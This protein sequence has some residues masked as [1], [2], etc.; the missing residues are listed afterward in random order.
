MEFSILILL[1]LIFTLFVGCQH[2]TVQDGNG[3]RTDLSS[4]ETYTGSDE[5]MPVKVCQEDKYT[6]KNVV[7]LTVTSL[8]IASNS[9]E[10]R[11][12][13]IVKGSDNRFYAVLPSRGFLVCI[14]L[15]TGKSSQHIFDG[16]T[17]AFPYKS[18]ASQGG[19]FYTG[20]NA[21]FYEFDPV[22]KEFT[23]I[24]N[25]SSMGANL[26]GWGFCE[27][28]EGFIYF[29]NY[30]KLYLYAFDPQTKKVTNLGLLDDV[31]MYSTTQAADSCGWVY[32]A[33]GTA[34]VNIIGYN[35]DTGEIKYIFPR[36]PGTG[37]ALV[38]KTRLG[39]VVAK[40][41]VTGKT[42]S[43]MEYLDSWWV[44][45]NG[46]I[47]DKALIT[48]NYYNNDYPWGL[49]IPYDDAP[50]FLNADYPAHTFTYWHPE[51]DEKTTV[52]FDYLCEGAACSPITLGPDGMIYGT[53]NHPMNVF[54]VDPLTDTVTDHG[55]KCIGSSVGNICAY[56]YQGDI[57]VG[58][59]Y[60]GGYIYRI[61]TKQGIISDK[62][63]INPHQE[64]IVSAISRPRSALALSDGK[65]CLFSGYGGYGVVGAGMAIYNVETRKTS[66]I[67]NENMLPYHG[68][69]AMAELPNGNV[70]CGS[71]V[72]PQ[73]GALPVCNTA[74]LFEFNPVTYEITNINYPMNNVKEIAQLVWAG[75]AVHGITT[76]GIYFVY[77][78]RTLKIIYQSNLSIYGNVVRQSM[79]ACSDGTIYLLM[80][81]SILKI[82]PDE[83]TV[84]CIGSLPKPAT[85][86]VAVTKNAVYYC[87][88]SEV[89]K[90]ALHWD[91]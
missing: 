7:S 52:V 54:T 4:V 60:S 73:G 66:V 62:S 30:P 70:I 8:G 47:V 39:E 49:H 67:E 56:A 64:K 2:N 18:F 28:D 44:L 45:K 78:Y 12:G 83:Y 23:T 69:L 11:S 59:A 65:T 35:T 91:D 50:N 3:E 16:N 36:L 20:A 81:K 88:G 13:A 89:C 37:S 32:S 71:T 5:T 6:Y 76:N 41:S 85:T 25:L 14:D 31:Q 43:D 80:S 15:H 40:M 17:S 51:T 74:A 86:G 1:I 63:N 33:I 34:E 75:N 27:D 77:D 57:L 29:S 61:D 46:E 22:I 10:A 72:L 24:T 48:R 87:S 82:D 21:Y 58:A 53:T 26:V 68:I 79:I 9:A 55:I 19:K 38:Y 42:N 90:A 84:K